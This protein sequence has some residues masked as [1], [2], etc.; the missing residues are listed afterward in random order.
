MLE[1]RNAAVP[2]EVPLVRSLFEQYAAALGVDL[3]FQG[4]A[5]ELASLPGAYA[6]PVGRLLLA[7]L[8]ARRRVCRARPLSRRA[9]RP[10]IPTLLA[11]APRM[12]AAL[13]PPA[14]HRPRVGSPLLALARRSS[15][16]LP[17][18]CLDTLHSMREA[19]TLYQSIGFAQVASYYENPVPGALFF[20]RELDTITS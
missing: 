10:V 6:P 18:V 3:C 14:R 8:D 5:A 16:R 11:I 20:T 15:G 17:R 12:R 7:W 19:I 1:V 4:F 2:D 13:R 9:A